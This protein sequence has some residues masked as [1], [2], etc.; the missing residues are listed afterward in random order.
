MARWLRICSLVSFA[1]LAVPGWAC[2]PFLYDNADLDH[3][4]LLEPGILNSTEWTAF[5]AFSSPPFG[6]PSG[7]EGRTVVQQVIH[8]DRLSDSEGGEVSNLLYDYEPGQDPVSVSANEAWWTDYFLKVRKRQVGAEEI[9][10][11]LYGP[12]RPQ[13]LAAQDR[14]YLEGLGGP[15]DSDKMLKKALAEARSVKNPVPLRHRWAFW[16]VRA[17]ALRS[18]PATVTVFREF[19]PGPADD[20]PL[21]R[22]Q[23]W[24]ASTL[25]ASRSPQA[26]DL[27][28]D[29]L[30]R[31]PSLRVQ[32]FSSLSTLDSSVWKGSTS[33]DA[34]LAK[35]FLD[36]RD[37]SPETLA[38][39]ASAEQADRGTGTK[40]ETVF[41]SMAEQV[42]RESGVFALF[43]L[44]DPNELSPRGLFTGL[45]DQA[46]AL[47]E[48][49]VQP[50]TRTWW[51][52][53][54]YL[55]LFDGDQARSA[56]LLDRARALPALNADQAQQTEL[57]ETLIAMDGEKNKDW[58]PELQK[59]I[60]ASMEWGRSLDAPGHNRGLYH[61]VVVLVAQKELTRGH[62]P[63]AALAFGLI[64]TGGMNPYQVA[65]DD[66]FWSEGWTANN[67]VNLLLDALMSD[68]DLALW[69]TLLHAPDLDPLA[70]YL[71]SRSFLDDND[72]LWWQA[73]RALRRGQ[74]DRAVTLL[75]TLGSDGPSGVFHRRNFSYSLT[76]DPLD[77]TSGR[78][79][80]SVSAL[81]LAG[82]MARVEDDARTK[83]SARSL[84]TQGEF[85]LS[86]QFSGLPLLFSDPPSV[87]SFV[88]GNFEYYGY[89]GLDRGHSTAV[90]GTFPL[91]QPSQTDAWARRLAAFYKN[92]FSTLGRARAAF[93]AVVA[94][95]E[96]PDAEFQALLFLQAIDHDQFK[97]L[98]DPRY[99]D[100]PL[101]DTLR[102]TCEDFSNFLEGSGDLFPLP[103]I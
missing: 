62:N 85:W 102:S 26:L 78:G 1:V 54:S 43:G 22:A 100:L 6:Q 18:D 98:A 3:F 72:I 42:E 67:S 70:A 79:M 80:R 99:E 10:K 40:T 50:A 101:A 32:T 4:S 11:V 27:W 94:R 75:K 30:V 74:G 96:D 48:K 5:L 65:Q 31:W 15:A 81:T 91:G 82:L 71:A 2:G 61:S 87:I 68:D 90:V 55:A 47:V 29:L 89:D 19:C 13:W 36:G 51:L 76:L 88:N 97:A 8:P 7:Q 58:T 41:Y 33:S 83:P 28:V 35:Y 44:V 95:H 53:A 12:E 77:P 63:L 24:A 57:L 45:I 17:M 84:L 20:L 64:Q 37:F 86:L 38:S 59:R 66:G 25:V 21:A 39:V 23:G 103:S 60:L 46:Q 9:Q 14:Q 16:A 69:K 93:Q 56:S 49:G 34:L 73:H 52:I 92:E